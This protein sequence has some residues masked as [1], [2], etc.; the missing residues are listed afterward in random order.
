MRKASSGEVRFK[1]QTFNNCGP[2]W[3]GDTEVKVLEVLVYTDIGRGRCGLML[4]RP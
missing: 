2:D 4:L 3:L 1:P